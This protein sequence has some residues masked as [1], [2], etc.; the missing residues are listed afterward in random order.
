MSATRRSRPTQKPPQTTTPK[1]SRKAPSL[2]TPSHQKRIRH[3]LEKNCLKKK[4]LLLAGSP[5]ETTTTTN[6]VT[7]TTTITTGHLSPAIR[8]QGPWALQRERGDHLEAELDAQRLILLEAKKVQQRL[9]AEIELRDAALE[10]TRRT[11]RQDKG[12]NEVLT[13][14]LE[15]LRSDLMAER[16]RNVG[17][18]RM[19]EE[20]RQEHDSKE[21]MFEKER[22]THDQLNNEHRAILGKLLE[23]QEEVDQMHV[24]YDAVESERNELQTTVLRLVEE[25]KLLRHVRSQKDTHITL[26]AKEKERLHQ[27]LS[28]EKLRVARRKATTHRLSSNVKSATRT[29][30][31]EKEQLQALL[32]DVVASARSDNLFIVRHA[33]LL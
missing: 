25:V 12:T 17:M 28:K 11:S 5:T 30:Q 7:P 29:K 13:S 32:G 15:D 1:T 24:L 33:F 4:N 6:P 23:T 16:A 22:I 19:Q 27:H 20:A 14:Q 21:Q 10:R 3:P 9:V 31:L 26:L 2:L 18:E 8:L